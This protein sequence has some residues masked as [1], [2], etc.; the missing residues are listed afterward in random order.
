MSYE[1]KFWSG[2][3]A[4]YAMQD[5]TKVEQQVVRVRKDLRNTERCVLAVLFLGIALLAI[6]LGKIGKHA[7]ITHYDQVQMTRMLDALH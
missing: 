2:L 4:H 6:T 1:E 7:G 3:R 5:L